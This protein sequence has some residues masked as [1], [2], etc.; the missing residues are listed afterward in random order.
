MSEACETNQPGAATEFVG[1]LMR[2]EV[3]HFE[4]SRASIIPWRTMLDLGV[5]RPEKMWNLHRVH[6]TASITTKVAACT[7]EQGRLRNPFVKRLLDLTTLHCSRLRSSLPYMQSSAWEPK[8][9]IKRCL[10]GMHLL[11]DST[12]FVC[13]WT[14]ARSI[15]R[16]ESLQ[17]LRQVA[18]ESEADFL[19]SVIPELEGES[20]QNGTDSN[21]R[22]II[23]PEQRSSFSSAVGE[24]GEAGRRSLAKSLA[25]NGGSDISSFA[26]ATAV[27]R[28]ESLQR[29]QQ[30]SLGLGNAAEHQLG[31]AL[32]V[33]RNL[34]SWKVRLGSFHLRG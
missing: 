13:S 15:T 2:T 31:R 29:L 6:C 28:W 7:E 5:T 12:C 18:R 14:C 26:D 20:E 17:V 33:C 3:A 23:G 4:R 11:L 10:C 22:S 1:V 21:Y 24:F 34:G 25:E 27:A 30:Q 19:C 32:E 9:K 16:P 8:I